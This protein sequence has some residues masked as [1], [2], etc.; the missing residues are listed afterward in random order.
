MV[1]FLEAQCL[2][3]ESLSSEDAALY[4][5]GLVSL[6]KNI[7]IAY[8]LCEEGKELYEKGDSAGARI[9][10]Q[11]A[12]MRDPSNKKAV[13]FLA[14][15]DK[16]KVP[17]KRKKDKNAASP[18][19]LD[20]EEIAFLKKLEKRVSELEMTQQ[21]QPE[22]PVSGSFVTEPLTPV[23]NM[24]AGSVSSDV[25][26]EKSATETAVED[27]AA[28]LA[29]IKRKKQ[30]EYLLAQGDQAYENRQFEKAYKFYKDAFE[31]FNSEE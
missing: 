26:N 24:P 7:L 15:C 17:E 23:P 12:L 18:K 2:S 5:E 31:A 10:F 20:A 4:P 11:Q 27:N 9:K 13:K 25:N 29:G 22:V 8:D 16:K 14:M 21:E 30:A 6:A 3:Q 28:L 1:S 19:A